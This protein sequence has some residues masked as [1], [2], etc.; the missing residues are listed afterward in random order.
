MIFDIARANQISPN[1]HSIL[2]ACIRPRL[3]IRRGRP[4]ESAEIVLT[5]SR[6]GW[7]QGD[8]NGKE[9][10]EEGSGGGNGI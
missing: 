2:D 5:R 4:F 9:R 7:R 10:D 8:G 1:R 3:D 6:S